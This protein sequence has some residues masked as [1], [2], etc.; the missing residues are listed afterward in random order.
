M[1]LPDKHIRFAESLLGL[2]AFVLEALD[3]PKSIDALWEELLPA[4]KEDLLPASHS[5]DNLVLAVD[6]LF[7]IQAVTLNPNGLLK[8]CASSS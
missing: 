4:M 6:M 7:A 2:G 8:R 1:Y 3:T 5:F